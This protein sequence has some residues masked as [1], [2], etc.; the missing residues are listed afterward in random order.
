[1]L[2]VY[3]LEDNSNQKFR[4]LSNIKKKYGNGNDFSI[5]PI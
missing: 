3:M 1:M 5:P 2:N 4:I